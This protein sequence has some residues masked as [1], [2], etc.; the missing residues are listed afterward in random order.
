MVQHDLN[1]PDRI[2]NKISYLVNTKKLIVI[3]KIK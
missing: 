2:K 3:R 1:K